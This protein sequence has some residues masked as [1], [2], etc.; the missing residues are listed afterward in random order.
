MRKHQAV[1]PP[2]PSLV[3]TWQKPARDPEAVATDYSSR[4]HT[5]S[6]LEFI[7]LAVGPASPMA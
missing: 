3:I 4:E 6:D 2:S 5:D 1:F 7:L